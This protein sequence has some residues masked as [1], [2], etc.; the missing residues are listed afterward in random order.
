MTVLHG[1]QLVAS[2]P[3]QYQE[4][5]L[6]S[7]P[8][9]GQLQNQ[10]TA[11]KPTSASANPAPAN[12]ANSAPSNNLE[13]LSI[14]ASPKQRP[15]AE[16]QQLDYQPIPPAAEIHAYQPPWKSLIEYAHS[17]P[18]GQAERLNPA[19]PRYQQLI[20]QVSLAGRRV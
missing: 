17:Q 7:S 1:V 12:S 4:E 5:Q 14:L 9:G 15:P 6:A 10:V 3:I 2:S 16:A 8:E 18:P 19:S 20:G 11:T 13:P